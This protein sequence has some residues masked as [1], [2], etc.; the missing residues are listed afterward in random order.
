MISENAFDVPSRVSAWISDWLTAKQRVTIELH[1]RLCWDVLLSGDKYRFRKCTVDVTW[2][3]DILFWR[4]PSKKG[5][6]FIGYSTLV[7]KRRGRL[8]EEDSG[9]RI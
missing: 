8:A 3:I 6:F 4:A 7:R 2:L 9:G 5:I 1:F